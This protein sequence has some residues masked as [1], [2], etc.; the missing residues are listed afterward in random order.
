MVSHNKLYGEKGERFEEITSQLMD[1]LGY[2]PTPEVI[3]ILMA[4][5]SN[6]DGFVQNKMT[7]EDTAPKLG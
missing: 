1:D 3:G 2:E 4:R 6:G 5:F 7:V